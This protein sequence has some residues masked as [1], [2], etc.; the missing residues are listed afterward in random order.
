MSR[1]P[2]GIQGE[3][4]GGGRG[5]GRERGRGKEGEGE[6]LINGDMFVCSHSATIPSPS[7]KELVGASYITSAL[8]LS[9]TIPSPSNKE[10][11]F[12]KVGAC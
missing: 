1:R 2:A 11:G 8:I 9:A 6:R 12:Q 5:R 4:E 3:R 7:D 10:L